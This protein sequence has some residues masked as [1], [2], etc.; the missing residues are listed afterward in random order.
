M[1]ERKIHRAIF[2]TQNLLTPY[3]K[4]VSCA[5]LWEASVDGIV[6]SFASVVRWIQVADRQKFSNGR[7]C[8]CKRKIRAQHGVTVSLML[9]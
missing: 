3:A 2:V 7:Y 8:H 6:C 4:D 1:E 9:L 5:T